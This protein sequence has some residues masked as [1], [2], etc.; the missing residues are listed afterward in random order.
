MKN[1]SPILDDKDIIT[2]E[3]AEK[4]FHQNL[5]NGTLEIKNTSQGDAC[6]TL[7]R[8][9]L[10]N[11]RVLNKYGV[12]HFQ[13]DWDYSTN[14]KTDYHTVFKASV[15]GTDLEF[16]CFTKFS[17][18]GELLYDGSVG[19]SSGSISIANLSKYNLVWAYIDGVS[20]GINFAITTTIP[21]SYLSKSTDNSVKLAGGIPLGAYVTSSGPQAPK[22]T[23][24]YITASI[25]AS[26]L[27]LAIE[28]GTIGNV[29][30]ISVI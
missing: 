19:A 23:N 11:W 20:S 4:N 5:S 15:G 9:N 18:S 30:I 13:T 1:L 28:N 8:G 14:S 2:K 24:S 10:A 21:I 26:K 25:T 16:S 12:L 27:N 3:Y 6:I 22:N 7:S 29:Q 17:K